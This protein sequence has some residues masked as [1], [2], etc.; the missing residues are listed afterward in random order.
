MVNQKT[1][2]VG[3]LQALPGERTEGRI[4]VGEMQDGTSIE[5]PVVLILISQHQR[6]TSHFD[7]RFFL[8]PIQRFSF[9]Q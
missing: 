8:F 2:I 1:I 9:H 3:E 7:N 4:P 5:L 6:G